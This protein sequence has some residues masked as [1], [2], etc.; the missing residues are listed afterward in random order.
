MSSSG[1]EE[2]IFICCFLIDMAEVGKVHQTLLIEG[3]MQGVLFVNGQFCGPME[4]EGQAFPLGRNAEVYVQLFPFGEGEPLAVQ[5]H[6][7]N[8]QIEKLEPEENAFSLVW[9][10]GVVQLE[11]RVRAQQESTPEEKLPVGVLLRYL[12]LRLAGDPQAQR[13]WLQPQRE[14]SLPDLSAYHAAV[15]LRFAPPSAPEQYDDRAGLVRR[16]AENVAVI[17]TALAVTAP[18]GQ[19]RRL[20]ESINILRT[21]RDYEGSLRGENPSDREP[22]P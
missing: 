8:G 17:D 7:R 22:Q 5:L 18:A 2:D 15:P 20:I 1:L 4:R 16:I 21:G 9:P 10:D 19:G 11:L 6:M 12:N 3:G 13:L 14:G